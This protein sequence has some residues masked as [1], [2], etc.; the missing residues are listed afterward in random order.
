MFVCFIDYCKAFD[1]VNYWKLFKQLTDNG[2]N[3]CIVKMLVYWY[4]H[5]QATVLWLNTKSTLFTLVMA[6]SKV[7]FYPHTCLLGIFD[8]CYL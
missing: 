8:S 7:A 1:K 3:G 2:V 5:Q 6:L 4:S